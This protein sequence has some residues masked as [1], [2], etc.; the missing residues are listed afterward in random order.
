MMTVARRT[1]QFYSVLK[2]SRPAFEEIKQKLVDQELDLKYIM[3]DIDGREV[4]V[5]GS[6]ALKAEQ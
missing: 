4:I 2:I 5:F 1:E 3:S 6:T